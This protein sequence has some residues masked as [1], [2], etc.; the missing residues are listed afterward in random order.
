MSDDDHEGWLEEVREAF[1][2]QL[3]NLADERRLRITLEMLDLLALEPLR[4]ELLRQALKN[5][6]PD[7][8]MHELLL[9]WHPSSCGR[10]YCPRPPTAEAML[11]T[12]TELAHILSSINSVTNLHLDHVPDFVSSLLLEAYPRL[13]SIAL[14]SCAVATADVLFCQHL[15]SSR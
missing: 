14:E 2:F 15:S 1:Q 12:A 4:L 5:L 8:E 6:L 10:V 13:E 9:H 3:E 7:N 11:A